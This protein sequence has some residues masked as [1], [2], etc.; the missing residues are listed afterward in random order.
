MES[1]NEIIYLKASVSTA[2]RRIMH[3]GR[4]EEK[5]GIAKRYLRDI[6]H[7]YEEYINDCRKRGIKVTVIDTDAP[8]AS[9]EPL[10]DDLIYQLKK[11]AA[12]VNILSVLLKEP[13][14]G[15]SNPS[16]PTKID[17]V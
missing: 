9:L 1:P 8:L 2:Y 6:E 12:E 14:N 3:R 7:F 15:S 13:K 16:L 10:Y 5:E 17:R 4:A 11:R